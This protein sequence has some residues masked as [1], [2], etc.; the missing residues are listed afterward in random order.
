MRLQPVRCQMR[1]TLEWLRPTAAAI[2]RTPN[3]CPPR[4]LMQRH[5]HHTLDL[6]L[7]SGRLRPG[8]RVASLRAP[9][10]PPRNNGGASA[11]PSACSC[12]RGRPPRWRAG[13]RPSAEQSEP[14]RRPSEVCCDPEPSSPGDPDQRREPQCVRSCPSEQHRTSDEISESPVS[15]RTLVPNRVWSPF[16]TRLTLAVLSRNAGLSRPSF[17]P[18]VL[19]SLTH[20]RRSV[21]GLCKEKSSMACRAPHPAASALCLSSG[22]GSS[23]VA[24]WMSGLG[25]PSRQAAA[26]RQETGRG[27]RAVATKP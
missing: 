7:P 1:C 22:M 18:A 3:A 15:D 4:L 23:D 14:A 13:V 24:R 5:V 20:K 27:C 12:R 25:V 2:V 8:G 16:G 26:S 11:A 9:R 19:P 6:A 17:R 10:R 21:V